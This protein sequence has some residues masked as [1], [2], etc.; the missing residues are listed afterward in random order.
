MHAPQ[1]VHDLHTRD[2]WRREGRDVR[3]S[4]LDR[5]AKRVKKRGAASGGA[6]SAS[7]G[8]ALAAERQVGLRICAG[9]LPQ[10]PAPL[11]SLLLGDAASWCGCFTLMPCNGAG[12]ST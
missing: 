7:S 4:E 8:S 9:L 6:S 1:D 11:P 5:P 10:H 3:A 2:R 12:R